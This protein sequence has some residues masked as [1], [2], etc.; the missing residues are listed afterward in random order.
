MRRTCHT[1]G[2]DST[3]SY[4]VFARRVLSPAGVVPAGAGSDYLAISTDPF[5]PG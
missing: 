3:G 4:D 2:C 1:L 5:M